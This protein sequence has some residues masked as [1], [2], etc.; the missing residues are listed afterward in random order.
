[1]IIY[2]MQIMNRIVKEGWIDLA[3]RWEQYLKELSGIE[4]RKEECGISVI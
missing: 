1:M 3:A 4:Y 2:R